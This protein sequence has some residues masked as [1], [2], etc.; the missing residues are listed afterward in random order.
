MWKIIF[1]LVSL[2]LSIIETKFLAGQCQAKSCKN[3]GICHKGPESNT[4]WCSCPQGVFG[5]RCERLACPDV[6]ENGG[7]CSRDGLDFICKCPFGFEGRFCERLSTN[8]ICKTESLCG[9]YGTCQLTNSLNEYKCLCQKGWIGQYCSER[10]PCPID[11]CKNGGSCNFNGKEIS[12][13]CP[14]NFDG[15]LC[16]HELDACLSQPCLNGRCISKPG[17]FRCECDKGFV[18][19]RCEN[20][21]TAYQCSMGTRN[22][23]NSCKNGGVCAYQDGQYS[24]VCPNMFE[25]AFCE[26]DV[27][28][29]AAAN[30][31]CRNG[32]TCINNNGGFACVCPNGFEG[33]L[34]EVDRDDCAGNPCSYGSTC[35]DG[36]AMFTCECPVG[37]TGVL[38]ELED[39]C[40]TRQPCRNGKCITDSSSGEYA[41]DCDKGFQGLHCDDDI[42]ECALGEELC[43]NNGT[44]VNTP[45]GYQCFCNK[46]FT[47]SHCDQL[48]SSCEPDPCL[49]HGICIDHIEHFECIC[50]EGFSGPRCE[51]H[52]TTCPEK[53][54]LNGGVCDETVCVCPKGYSGMFCEQEGIVCGMQ[55][56][57][58][59]TVCIDNG[60]NNLPVCGCPKGFYGLD[61]QLR[62]I[63]NDLNGCLTNPC[64][65]GSCQDTSDGYKCICPKGYGGKQCDE[66]INHCNT[67]TCSNNGTCV[68]DING[69]VCRCPE[70]FSGQRCE[71]RF[72]ACANKSCGSNAVCEIDERFATARCVCKKGFTG[73]FCDQDVDECAKSP[74]ENGSV[75]KNTYGGYQ[76]KCPNQYS[77]VNCEVKQDFC[78]KNPCANNGTCV[79]ESNGFKCLCPS[80]FSGYTCQADID[81][82]INNPCLNGATC[83]DAVDSYKCECGPGFSG[84]DCQ[85]NVDECKPYGL[86]LN[87]GTCVDGINSYKCACKRGFTGQNCQT[88]VDVDQFN[89]TDRMEKDFCKSRNCASKAH[90]GVCDEECN[91]FGCDYDGNDC[92]AMSKPYSKCTHASYCSRVFRD[93]KCDEICNNEACLFDGFD[94]DRPSPNCP[95]KD[96]CEQH[97]ADNRCDQKCNSLGCGFDGGDCEKS[98]ENI[99]FGDVLMV[100]LSPPEVF[101]TQVNKFLMTLSSKLRASI[102]IK[103]DDEGPMIFKWTDGNTGDRVPVSADQSLSISYGGVL[104]Q[105]RNANR[106][107]IVW[108][109]I[110]VASCSGDCFS[111]VDIVANYLGQ[112]QAKKELAEIGMPIYEAIA[113]RPDSPEVHQPSSF[114]A[115]LLCGIGVMI[116][117][118]SIY[119]LQQQR[120]TRKRRIV[121]APTWYPPT[122]AQ[123]KQLSIHQAEHTARMNLFGSNI[124]LCNCKRP[125]IDLEYYNPECYDHSCGS[126]ASTSKPVVFKP[127]ASPSFSNPSSLHLQASSIEPIATPIDAAQVNCRAGASCR[128]P[129]MW[130]AENTLKSMDIVLDDVQK[131]FNAGADL[132]MQDDC[133]ETALFVACRFGR[134]ELVRKLLDLGAD[135]TIMNN[136]NSTCLHQASHNGDIRLTKE[137][138]R[139]KSVVNEI[140]EVDEFDRTALMVCAMNCIL[141]TEVAEALIEAGADPSFPGDKSARTY[142][143]R[144][145]LHYAAQYSNIKMLKYLLA[146]GAN[147]DA[148]DL[149]ECTPLFLAAKEGRLESVIM[150]VEAGASVEITDQKERTPREI[151]ED[152]HFSEIVEVLNSKT[153]VL[154]LSVCNGKSLVKH[155]KTSG[156]GVKRVAVKRKPQP[157]TPPH[158]DG[159]STPS[160]DNYSLGR[161][162]LCNQ[163]TLLDSPVSDPMS[164]HRD[165]KYSPTNCTMMTPTYWNNSN[166]YIKSSPPYEE[167][168]SEYGLGATSFYSSQGNPFGNS[169]IFDTSSTENHPSGTPPLFFPA[170]QYSSQFHQV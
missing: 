24:C 13:T 150:L 131:L 29:C 126:I 41:C 40:V 81:D 16:Q 114:Y 76:C 4:H 17:S 106:G 34:C 142:K 72:D 121:N 166:I 154:P 148:Q 141:S 30:Q 161:P 69:F 129:L 156:K 20:R 169:F 67:T 111:D 56:C 152:Q 12:C 97:Y 119:V 98:D 79:E 135:P 70:P 96:Y 15:P 49:N 89:I 22:L 112:A 10:D 11:Y 84:R 117:L 90:N 8:N 25:G 158:S 82:C 85:I 87:G 53:A 168:H 123:N 125:K 39:Q 132:N 116:I 1:F 55:T 45:G 23:E 110:D 58:S 46:P 32:G 64:L 38:C 60:P 130:L 37:K 133:E 147:K 47:G 2:Q 165:I 48:M 61:C 149:E 75:C 118:G 134:Y 100:I 109:N 43:Y 136:K 113:R 128:T 88:F 33:E 9:P 26:K 170:C 94:C 146:E 137:L 92:S 27:N 19:S 155:G 143:G 115:A 14:A 6:C 77:G 107:V 99:L 7:Q 157:L 5:S 42:N 138:L 144:T 86:C 159:V 54:C 28:E 31:P 140:N 80:G 73:E 65:H 62:E 59:G 78:S 83:V 68:H 51:V 151:A 104:R 44:C 35:V 93:H 164:S 63:T 101:V 122:E 74:C 127:P 103:S 139:L 160:P 66:P 108:I 71:L 167:H 162:L 120:R 153:T 102:R 145:A 21:S 124:D 163:S 36:L 18:G 57:P 105:K 95:Y 91:F 50:K 3:G 52:G